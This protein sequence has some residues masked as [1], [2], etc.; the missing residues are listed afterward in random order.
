MNPSPM[1]KGE[2]QLRVFFKSFGPIRRAAGAAVIELDVDES[3]TI[4]D[5][6]QKA[7]ELLGMQLSHLIMT[8]GKVSGNLILLLNGR[9]T[10]RFDGL[11]TIVSEDDEVIILPHVQGG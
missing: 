2:Y 7:I 10:Q 9:D 11:N 1:K 5:V 6:I 3:S 8:N 4:Q